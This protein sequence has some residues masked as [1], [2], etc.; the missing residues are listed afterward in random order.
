MRTFCLR[1][2][3]DLR[4]VQP[5]ADVQ[6]AEQQRPRVVSTTLAVAWVAAG[7]RAAAYITDGDLQDSVHFA[8]G[9]A[10][11]RARRMRGDRHPMAA[12]AHPQAGN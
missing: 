1:N 2:P 8:S 9:I 10:L 3:W 4:A 7:R 12:D 5:L 6:F 11:Y